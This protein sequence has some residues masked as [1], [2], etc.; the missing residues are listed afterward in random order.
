[1]VKALIDISEEANRMINIVKAE[2]GLKDKSQAINTMA[3][4]YKESVFE[5]RIRP[6]YIRKLKRI[7]KEK[8]VHIGT[9]KDF[10][11]MFHIKK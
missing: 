9:I 4:E 10:D 5:P 1:M 8:T 7:Q 3:R 2:H 11:K 6:E